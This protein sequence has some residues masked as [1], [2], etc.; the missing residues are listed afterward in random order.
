MCRREVVK[1]VG[2]RSSVNSEGTSGGVP[3]DEHLSNDVC[4]DPNVYGVE[5]MTRIRRIP[6]FI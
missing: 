1:W 5:S 4:R 6:E 3:V 2:R